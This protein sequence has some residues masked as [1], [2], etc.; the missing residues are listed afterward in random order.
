MKEKMSIE[1]SLLA[2]DKTAHFVAVCTMVKLF[3]TDQ[4]DSDVKVA[5][6]SVVTGM[7]KF[8]HY[9]KD[10]TDPEQHRQYLIAMC[11]YCLEVLKK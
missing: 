4:S 11:E 6:E 2:T 9:I 10:D 1:M 3:S 8:S 5:T 7:P